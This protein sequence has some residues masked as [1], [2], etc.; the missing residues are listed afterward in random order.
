MQVKQ[1][2]RRF[3]YS[4]EKIFLSRFVQNFAETLPS[5]DA[6]NKEAQ[7]IFVIFKG[8]RR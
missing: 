8:K 2:S 3:I 5:K 1:V 7:K 4:S 6:F